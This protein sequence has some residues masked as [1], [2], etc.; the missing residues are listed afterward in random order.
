MPHYYVHTLC[1]AYI[2][3]YIYLPPLS[4]LHVCIMRINKYIH[5]ICIYPYASKYRLDMLSDLFP[6]SYALVLSPIFF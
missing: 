4:T 1:I 3:I 2:Y 5:H 6:L